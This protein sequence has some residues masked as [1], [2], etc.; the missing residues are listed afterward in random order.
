DLAQV[1]RNS[2]RSLWQSEAVE[3]EGRLRKSSRGGLRGSSL[4][5]WPLILI[6][7]SSFGLGSWGG[8]GGEGGSG[9]EETSGSESEPTMRQSLLALRSSEKRQDSEMLS[10]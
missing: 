7:G 6:G 1:S 9:S 3:V 8:S 4:G 10:K 5:S 2:S